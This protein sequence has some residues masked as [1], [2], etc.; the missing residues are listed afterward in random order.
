MELLHTDMKLLL[1]EMKPS[2][3][4]LPEGV[5]WSYY[6]FSVWISFIVNWIK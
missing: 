3:Q 5:L 6:Q 1:G 4:L 2:L